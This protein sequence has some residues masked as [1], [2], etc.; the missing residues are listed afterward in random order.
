MARPE[1]VILLSAKGNANDRE[2]PM[3]IRYAEQSPASEEYFPLFLSTGWND[4]YRFTEDEIRAAIS[5]SWYVVSA[6]D[7]GKLI[8]FGRTI[9]DGVHHALVVDMIV[10]PEYQGRGIGGEILKMIVVECRSHNIRD[11]QLFAAKGKAGFYERHGFAARPA[12][13]PGMELK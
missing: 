8:G 2:T 1:P 12:D 6:Y 9:S 10:H 11:I 3:N 4:E 5:G 13:A 7:G